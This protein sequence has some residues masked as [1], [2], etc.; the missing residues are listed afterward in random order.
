MQQQNNPFRKAEKAQSRLRMAIFG[1]SGSG[2]T[3]TALMIASGLGERIAVIDTEHGSAALYSDRVPFD[4]VELSVYHPKQFI[5]AIQ[6]AAE[7]KY[8]VLVIDSLSHAWSGSGGVLEIVDKAAAQSNS[9]NSFD[10]W[11]KGTPLHN[12][13]V[14]AILAAPLHVIVTMR[15][16]TEYVLEKNERGKMEPRKVGLSPVQRDGMEYEFSVVGQMNAEHELLISKTRFSKLDNEL[17]ANPDAALGAKLKGWLAEGVT[18]A[19]ALPKAEPEPEPASV[20]GAGIIKPDPLD[21]TDGLGANV[22]ALQADDA[23][24]NV[25]TVD[26]L[27]VHA[28]RNATTFLLMTAN[29]TN[30]VAPAAALVGL[31]VNGMFVEALAQGVY[32]LTPVWTVQADRDAA[33][34]WENVSVQAPESVTA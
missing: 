32:P 9:R 31:Q 11:R 7:A 19:P 6:A 34:N 16:K 13:L 27:K 3:L 22:T 24:P 21:W 15:S 1:A 26:R 5:D 10:A 29:G 12:Q 28:S 14:D 20:R 33:G 2:K 8:D 25:Y 4:V 23:P 30:I 18:P 17:I